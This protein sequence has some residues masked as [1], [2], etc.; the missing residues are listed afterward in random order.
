MRLFGFEVTKAAVAAIGSSASDRVA[1]GVVSE[2]YAGAWQQNVSASIDG[3]TSFATVYSCIWRISADVGKM[4]ARLMKERNA[5]PGIWDEVLTGSPFLP[6]MRKPN[7]FMTRQQF[8]EHWL[9]MKLM[10]GNFYAVKQRD[11]RGVV[12]GL[13]PLHSKRVRVL[14]SDD[15]DVGYEVRDDRLARRAATAV[16]PM[17]E[18]IHDRMMTIFHPLVGV[19]PLVAAAATATQGIRIQQHSARFFANQA[20]PG[21]ILV[22]PGAMTREQAEHLKEQMEQGYAG[23]NIG[24]LMVTGNGLK[25]EPIGAMPAEQAQLVEQ[26]KWTA[27]DIARAFGVPLY[28]LGIGPPPLSSLTALNQQYY[29]DTIHPH[30]EAIET[31]YDEGFA[32]GDYATW[33]DTENLL[34]MDPTTLIDV[35]A[36]GV[37]A[38]LVAPDEGRHELNLGKVPGGKFP[39]LQQQN[40]SLEALAKR[41]AENPLGAAAQGTGRPPNPPQPGAEPEDAP[42]APDAE[43]EDD[44]E[45]ARAQ[46]ETFLKSISAGIVE[47]EIAS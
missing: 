24:R 21:G 14:V 13:Y 35:Q 26:L 37:G 4:R 17:S 43:E 30:V 36:K 18:I 25:Y 2:P 47:I 38:G 8:F 41:D 7:P 3:V 22:A 11:N 10:Y 40:Y 1:F 9:H 12:T 45:G 23:V 34:R 15:G 39:Y 16:L 27:E 44:E 33:L 19:A 29:G 28:K 31:L 32:L 46:V 5:E 6:V 42:R 20:R